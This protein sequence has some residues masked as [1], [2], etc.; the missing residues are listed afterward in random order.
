MVLSSASLLIYKPSYDL[1]FYRRNKSTFKSSQ[2][3]QTNLVTRCSSGKKI[4]CWE[5]GGI[6]RELKGQQGA[7]GWNTSPAHRLLTVQAAEWPSVLKTLGT[8]MSILRAWRGC[9]LGNLSAF[10]TQC[11]THLS[12]LT[13]CK[14]NLMGPSPHQDSNSG[15]PRPDMRLL[16]TGFLDQQSPRS[17]LF[18]FQFPLSTENRI[19]ALGNLKHVLCH[20]G[21][22]PA[23]HWLPKQ[24]SL[25]FGISE[26]EV[27]WEMKSPS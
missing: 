17:A 20:W 24:T 16:N 15:F 18:S 25:T 4:Q 19:R 26:E 5:A 13:P 21:T 7:S 6:P 3:C 11:S 9:S 27:R 22:L 10:P 14:E 8:Y 23:P 12:D 1:G 2:S